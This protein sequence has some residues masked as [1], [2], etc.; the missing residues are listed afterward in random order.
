MVGLLCYN[1][2]PVRE[3]ATGTQSTAAAVRTSA[4]VIASG[5]RRGSVRYRVRCAQPGAACPWAGQILLKGARWRARAHGMARVAVDAGQLFA[6]GA[7]NE[8]AQRGCSAPT[9]NASADQFVKITFGESRRR[10][11]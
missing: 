2:I 10:R 11:R 7:F 3:N 8:S 1:H 4:R 5:A 9:S 6:K